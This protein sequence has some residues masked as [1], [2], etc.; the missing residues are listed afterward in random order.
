MTISHSIVYD[1]YPLFWSS[2]E[3]KPCYEGLKK[4]EVIKI[5]TK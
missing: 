2:Y 4:I 1:C 5:Y 3:K